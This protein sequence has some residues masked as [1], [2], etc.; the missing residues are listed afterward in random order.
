[1]AIFLTPAEET[2]LRELL[3]KADQVG[4]YNKVSEKTAKRARRLQLVLNKKGA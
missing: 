4:F 3:N 1:M 2:A